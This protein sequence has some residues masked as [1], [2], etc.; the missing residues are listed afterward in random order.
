MDFIEQGCQACERGDYLQALADFT[1]AIEEDGHSVDAFICRGF[2]QAKSGNVAEAINNFS[3]GIELCDPK[4]TNLRIFLEYRA[5]AYAKLQDYDAAAADYKA[6]IDAFFNN[7][8]VF[9]TEDS[10]EEEKSIL[11]HPKFDQRV[12]SRLESA[13]FQVQEQQRKLE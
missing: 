2:A 3:S 1:R 8:E 10:D 6:A 4:S 5:N 9:E 11:L 12:L 13:L 7:P